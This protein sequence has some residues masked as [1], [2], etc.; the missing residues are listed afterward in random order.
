V[1]IY[2][3]CLI[4]L[5]SN[6]CYHGIAYAVHGIKLPRIVA[7]WLLELDFQLFNGYQYNVN[8]CP[9]NGSLAG[10]PTLFGNWYSGDVRFGVQKL[11]SRYEIALLG[12]EGKG[13]FEKWQNSGIFQCN[14]IK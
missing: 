6:I 11:Q 3:D 10:N 9:T 1:L 14:K 8:I 13:I 5:G 2:Y 12:A 4:D 7:S